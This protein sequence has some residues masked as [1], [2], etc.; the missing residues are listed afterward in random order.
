[1][2]YVACFRKVRNPLMIYSLRILHQLLLLYRL[3]NA[4]A[5]FEGDEKAAGNWKC[6]FEYKAYAARLIGLSDEKRE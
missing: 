1:M 2:K 4:I 3:L 5:I 6:A